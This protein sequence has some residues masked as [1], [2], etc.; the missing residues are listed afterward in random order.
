VGLGKEKL[1][2]NDYITHS[3][4]D[5]YWK[6]ISIRGDGGDRKYDKITIPVFLMGGWYDYYA[7]ASFNSFQRL[8]EVGAT[9][10]IRIVMSATDHQNNVVG[11]RDFTGGGKDELGLA[12]RWLDYILKGIDNG[13]K[14]EPPVKIFVMGINKWREENEWPLARTQFTKYYFHSRNGSRIGAL[15]TA[16][17]DDQSPTKY[18]YDPDDP[19]PTLGGGHSWCWGKNPLVPVGSYDHRPNENRDDVL[20]FTS[21]PM[22]E[23][24]EV[25][26]PIVIKLYA[27]STAKD[28]DFTAILM[29]VYPN[30]KEAYNLC[31]GIIRARFRESVWDPPKLLTPG[32]IYEY[33]L[34]LQPTSNVFLKGHS[35]RVQL[36][37]SNFPLWDRNP[38]TGHEQG[39][40]AKLQV[41]EQTIYHDQA[42]PSHIILPIIK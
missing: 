37:S 42:H 31:E 36:T 4:Y 10:D 13:I 18:I 33:T 35:I 22:A 11:S 2:W 24:T 30:G 25:T 1:L 16:L 29:D 39:M 21:A 17:P 32:Q 19:V 27:A 20:V 23:D 6:K 14:D 3:T 40:D 5:D 12:I 9:D 41:A 28:T 34:E 26:G 38:N 7:G 8:R 15:S